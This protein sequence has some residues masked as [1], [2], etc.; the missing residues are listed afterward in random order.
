MLKNNNRKKYILPSVL[1]IVMCMVCFVG[2]AWA[3][4]EGHATVRVENIE[5]ATYGV[6]VEVRDSTDSVVAKSS[7][8]G[9]KQ[10]LEI[11]SNSTYSV[12]ITGT[13]NVSTGYCVLKFTD[14]VSKEEKIY[15]TPI[16]APGE[17]FKFTYQ[18]GI[19]ESVE[20]MPTTQWENSVKETKDTLT[21]ETFWGTAEATMTEKEVLGRAPKAKPT[22]TEIETTWTIKKAVRSDKYTSAPNQITDGKDYSH[23]DVITIPKKGTR[24]TFTD[25]KKTSGSASNQVYVISSWKL[26]ANGKWVIDMDGTNIAGDSGKGNSVIETVS[27]DGKTITYSYVTSKDNEHIRLCYHS[28]DKEADPVIYSLY[29]GEPGTAESNK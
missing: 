2:V 22:A 15:Y 3:W 29:T 11:G 13:G 20:G 19:F 21:V 12:K 8:T 25:D 1:V 18:N 10:T 17:S 14:H 16:I 24:I 28:K 4:Y 23:T 27:S 6:K 9:S 26:D 5:A 7:G